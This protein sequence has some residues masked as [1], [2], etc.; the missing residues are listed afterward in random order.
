MGLSP[1]KYTLVITI[2][3]DRL[4]KYLKK[5]EVVVPRDTDLELELRFE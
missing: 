2:Y 3:S 5:W 1:G 4:D